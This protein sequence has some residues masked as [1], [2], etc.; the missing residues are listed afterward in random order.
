[1]CR[2]FA[3]D[4]PY[5]TRRRAWHATYAATHPGIAHTRI[6]DGGTR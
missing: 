3:H 6:R 1:M 4:D 5:N 2:H